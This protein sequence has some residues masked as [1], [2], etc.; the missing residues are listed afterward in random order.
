MVRS[1]VSVNWTGAKDIR[2]G[3][4]L[5]HSSQKLQAA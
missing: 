5:A 3:L 4:M 1:S 2:F